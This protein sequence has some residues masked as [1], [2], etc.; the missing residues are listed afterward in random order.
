MHRINFEWSKMFQRAVKGE[1]YHKLLNLSMA[2]KDIKLTADFKVVKKFSN[3]IKSLN[4][5]MLHSPK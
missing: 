3:D 2:L 5:E 4:S 1:Y